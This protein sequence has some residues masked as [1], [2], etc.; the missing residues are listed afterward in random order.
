[1]R[2]LTFKLNPGWCNI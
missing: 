1:V 2:D